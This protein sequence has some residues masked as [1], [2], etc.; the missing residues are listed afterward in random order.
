[1]VIEGTTWIDVGI[2]FVAGMA[3]GFVLGHMRPQEAV[4]E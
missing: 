3:L 1:M 4:S 2:V